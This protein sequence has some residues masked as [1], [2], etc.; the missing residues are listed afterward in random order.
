MILFKIERRGIFLPYR[1]RTARK[2]NT[3]YAG[4]NFR[5]MIERVDLAVNV[6]LPDAAR[7]ELGKLR[8]KVKNEDFFLHGQR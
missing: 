4:V 1:I 7:D 2:D 8:A 6:E 3:L 5:K